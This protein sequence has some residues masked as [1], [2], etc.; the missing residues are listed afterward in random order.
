MAATQPMIEA[1]S[2]RG[3]RWLRERKLKLALWVAV[4]EGIVVAVSHD[5]T[6]WTVLVIG[7]IV[8]AFYVLAGRS[9]K[10]DVG[11]HLSWIAAASQAMALL[12]VLFAFIFEWIAI[13]IVAIIAIAA[14]V[15]LFS[16]HRRT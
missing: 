2:T 8:L 12:V 9:M 16:D 4:V 13:G 7:V 10:W 15:Y 1:G 3:G 11:R 14:L 5:L 6:R